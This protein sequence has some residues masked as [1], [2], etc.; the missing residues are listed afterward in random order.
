LPDIAEEEGP[1]AYEIDLSGRV[2]FVTGASSGLGSQ[3]ARTLA[4]AGAGV[5]LAARRIERLKTLRA[6]IEAAGGDAHVVALDV[7]DPD[8]IKAAVAHAETEM[9]TIDILV[10]NS[11]VSTTQKLVDVQPE[12]FDY[13][14]NTNARGAFFVAQEVARRMVGRGTGR[15]VNIGSLAAHTANGHQAAY[16]AT[17]GAI[18]ALTRVMAFELAPLGIAVNS[19]CPGPIDTELAASMLTPQ[20]RRAREERIPLRKLGQPEDVAALVAF[21]LSDDAAYI[22]GADLVVDG[23]LL[24]AGIEAGQTATVTEPTPA[25]RAY[26]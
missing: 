13:V 15:I 24:I 18:T 25:Q 10:N 12:D 20:S 7:T 9:G 17:K 5:V 22:N 26:P 4:R 23:G 1:M 16:A 3:F 14:M 11:G 6:E 2:A 19:V 8:S 21:L